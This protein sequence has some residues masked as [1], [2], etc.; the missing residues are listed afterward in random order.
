[1]GLRRVRGEKGKNEKKACVV[2]QIFALPLLA[3]KWKKGLLSCLLK[4]CAE[5][6][7]WGHLLFL[8]GP[9]S[10]MII[11]PFIMSSCSFAPKLFLFFF[12]LPFKFGYKCAHMHTHKHLLRTT[13]AYK[14]VGVRRVLERAGGRGATGC[15]LWELG[16]TWCLERIQ[17]LSL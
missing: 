11:P 3:L 7:F 12:F 17:V 8:K 5:L 10:F 1:M 15:I 16:C 6:S 9:S 13:T 14:Q 2:Y 4:A